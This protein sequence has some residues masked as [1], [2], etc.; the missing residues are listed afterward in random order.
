MGRSAGFSG[1]TKIVNNLMTRSGHNLLNRASIYST[2]RIAIVLA[3]LI[4]GASDTIAT[5]GRVAT[6]DRMSHFPR[7]ILWAWERRED[8][9]FIDPNETAVAYLAR[10]LELSGDSVIVR[11]RFQPLT[12]PPRTILIAVVRIEV[13]RRLPPTLSASQRAETARIIAGL[14]NRWP[15]AI[16]ID[17]DATRSERAFY[18]DLLD[19]VRRRL[20]PS[21]PLSMTALASWCLDDD[22]LSGLP[23]D[24]AVPM[25]YRMGP[26]AKEISA[27]LRGGGQFTPTFSRD[28]IGLSL[29]SQVG[30]LAAGKR[31]YLFSP[32]PWTADALRDA[33]SEVAK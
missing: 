12:V 11:P 32:R 22:W 23:V 18:R 27:Y 9:A 29:D 4:A 28:S 10:T 24:E 1:W 30:G 17:F 25:I 7:V 3:A 6:A 26:D 8:L 21:M 2:A 31:V 20:P 13:D 33:I 5:T 16:Q 19:D 15:A 14:A